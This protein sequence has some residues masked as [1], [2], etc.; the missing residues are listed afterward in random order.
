MI[1]QSLVDP[2]ETLQAMTLEPGLE[3]L[4]HNVSQQ[5]ISG[6]GLML[7][8]GLAERLFRALKEGAR[9]VEQLGH[10][11]I[12]VVSPSIRLWLSRLLRHRI[13]D[14]TVLSYSEIPEDQ[15]VKVIHTVAATIS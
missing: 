15:P 9:Q 7:E 8:P 11:A 12:L 14:L 4:L 5:S 10:A 2:Q 1:I 6:Q 13:P 3:Q